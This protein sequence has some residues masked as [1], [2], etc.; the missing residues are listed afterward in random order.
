[1]T[2]RSGETARS[3][4]LLVFAIQET[5]DDVTNAP[6]KSTASGSPRAINVAQQGASLTACTCSI[7]WLSGGSRA[8]A[9]TGGIASA[10]VSNGP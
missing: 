10:R 9:W 3:G 1:M 6:S 2:Q 5:M 7:I 8:P 4:L